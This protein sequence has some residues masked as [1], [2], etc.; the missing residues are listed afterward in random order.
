ME[1]LPHLLYSEAEDLLGYGLLVHG[2]ELLRCDLSK[3]YNT[4]LLRRRGHRRCR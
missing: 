2:L 3:P 4:R 1:V